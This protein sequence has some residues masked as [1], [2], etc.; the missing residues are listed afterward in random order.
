[1]DD[2]EERNSISKRVARHFHDKFRTVRR[3]LEE[4]KHK[5]FDSNWV[6]QQ[7]KSDI[8][9]YAFISR[10][11]DLR[12]AGEISRTKSREI[13]QE[14]LNFRKINKVRTELL[15]QYDAKWV[16]KHALSEIS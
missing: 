13:I 9:E 12:E 8:S 3:E 14:F 5:Q 10:I 6:N 7:A 4:M 11:D 2:L 1:M 15:E 16:E